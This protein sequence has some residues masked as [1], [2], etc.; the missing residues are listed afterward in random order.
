MSKKMLRSMMQV[1]VKNSNQALDFYQQAFD[2]KLQCNHLDASG[3]VAHA[4]LNVFGQ[5]LAIMEAPEEPVIG[6]TM[7][8]CLHFGEG[9]EKRVTKIYDAL[10]EGAQIL[11]PLGPC[12]YS[13][14]HADFIDKYGVRWCIFV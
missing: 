4:E 13:P 14:L 8:F 6:N 9:H 2:A 11:S 7:M 12:D 5:V 10:K 3:M 1:F